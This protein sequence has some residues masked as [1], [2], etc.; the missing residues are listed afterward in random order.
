MSTKNLDNHGR[1]RSITVAFRV[2][3][4]ENAI[5]NRLVAISGLTKQDYISR[6]LMERDVLVYGNPRVYK[7]L[8][9]EMIRIHKELSRLSNIG[10]V[11]YELQE[12]LK[13]V[14]SIYEGMEKEGVDV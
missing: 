14:A 7:A 2:S 13:V 12:V 1:W 5:I 3:D 6:R 11:S 10:E 8:K 9:S 4:E